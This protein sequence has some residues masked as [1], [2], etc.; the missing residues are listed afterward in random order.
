MQR[1]KRGRDQ[2]GFEQLSRAHLSEPDSARYRSSYALAL[3]RVRGEFM[4][5]L[6]LARTAVHQECYNPDLYLNLARIYLNFNFKPEA[7]RFIKRGLMIDPKH[8]SLREAMGVLGSRRSPALKFLPRDHPL[9]RILGRFRGR[10][11]RSRAGKCVASV[12]ALDKS[13]TTDNL[14]RLRHG[15]DSWEA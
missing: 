2:D 3:A 5:A 11:A 15:E 4:Q 14:P 12:F 8:S 13:P 10:V 6:S 7:V 9:N 1:L